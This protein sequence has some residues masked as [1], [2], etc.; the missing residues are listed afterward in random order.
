MDVIYI[1][2]ARA[3]FLKKIKHT[4]VLKSLTKRLNLTGFALVIALVVDLLHNV[5][6]K[7]E[8]NIPLPGGVDP[9]ERYPFPD[10]ALGDSFMI[11]D[12]TWIKNLR[13]AAYMYSRRH[14]GTRFTCR[15]HGEGWRLWR[16]A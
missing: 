12:A 4:L 6:M 1:K 13:S 8:K 14:P 11:L 5:G 2:C 15:R 3:N 9:R 16:V 10:M 7:I